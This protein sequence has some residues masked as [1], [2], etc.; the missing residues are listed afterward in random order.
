MKN[1]QLKAALICVVAFALGLCAAKFCLGDIEGGLSTSDVTK[2]GELEARMLATRFEIRL[3]EKE[4]TKTEL[5][6]KNDKA[7]MKKL[8]DEFKELRRGIAKILEKVN[9]G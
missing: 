4:I 1:K 3:V 7:R 6:L 9:S 5:K 8:Y 2:L